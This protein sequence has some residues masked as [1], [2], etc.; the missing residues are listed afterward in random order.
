MKIQVALF[1]G[2]ALS[3]GTAMAAVAVH[4]D[5]AATK[6]VEVASLGAKQVEADKAALRQVTP[7]ASR[8]LFLPRPL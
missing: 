4:G 3:L 5:R 7:N 8:I 2:L 1:A 6:T